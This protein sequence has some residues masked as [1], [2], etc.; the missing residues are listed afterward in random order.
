MTSKELRALLLRIDPEG[1]M[2]VRIWDA[3][4]EEYL[5]VTDAIADGSGGAVIDLYGDPEEPGHE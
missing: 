5:P 1:V 2:P 3:D 4:S